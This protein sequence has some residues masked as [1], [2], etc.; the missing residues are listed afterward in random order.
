MKEQVCVIIDELQSFKYKRWI[1][2][3]EWDACGRKPFNLVSLHGRKCYGG[4]DL[5]LTSGIASFV[6]VFPPED[7]IEG[8]YA[9]LCF[10]WLPNDSMQAQVQDD[11]APYNTWVQNG[12]IEITAGNVI[13]Y[14]FVVK[15]LESL[16]RIYDIAEIAYDRW[17]PIKVSQYL[18][19]SGFVVSQFRQ[20]RKSIFSPS[21]RLLNLILQE[22]LIHGNNPVLKWM[23]GNVVYGE[24]LGGDIKFDKAQALEKA[25]G[26]FALIMALDCALKR[27]R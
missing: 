8:D 13:D 14:L 23:A 22:R 7:T 18:E 2:T 4:L 17:G 5:S 11:L 9:V 26:I 27:M 6:L 10:F 3:G 19:A 25:G 24:A 20:G 16:G 1:A 12:F 15:A 21:K